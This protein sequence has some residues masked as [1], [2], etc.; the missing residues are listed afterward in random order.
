MKLFVTK[1]LCSTR[2]RKYVYDSLT[3]D[4]NHTHD[5]FLDGEE[6]KVSD[7][8]HPMLLPQFLRSYSGFIEAPEFSS[9]A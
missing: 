1:F 3:I 9:Y 8:L 6:D 4:D 2:V 5:Q 7:G